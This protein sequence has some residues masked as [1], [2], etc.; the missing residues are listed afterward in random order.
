M[1][2][3]IFKFLFLTILTILITEI[4][5][6]VLN[7]DKLI[8]S[9]LSEQLTTQQIE[10]FLNLQNKWQ[11]LGYFFAPVML[12]IKTTLITSVIYVGTFFFSKKEAQYK[13]LWDIVIKAEFIFLLVPFFKIIW[14]Y[15]FQ[16]NYE[17]EDFQYFYPL[18]A[19]N[20]VGYQGLEAWFIY[21]FQ[22]LNLFE[23]A[24]WL[25]LAFYIGKAT[26][27]NM[28]NGLKIVASSYGLAL[29]LWVA[30]SMFFTLN[31]S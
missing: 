19:I 20:I 2:N 14:F 23:L 8:Y 13:I 1:K 4:T 12:L 24:Y 17:L 26:K 18:S 16:T 7:L 22:V 27:T 31:Y 15:F 9:S 10:D 21:P 11:W 6:S 30:V 5:K 28:D 3:L 25:I 29:F